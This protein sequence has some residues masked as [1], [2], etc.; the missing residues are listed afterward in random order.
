MTQDAQEIIITNRLTTGTTF[1]ARASDNTSVFVP[2]KVADAC[3]LRPGDR[4]MAV[5]V[6]NTARPERTPWVA[7]R[8]DRSVPT[9][10]E[11]E[12]LDSI[13]TMVLSA[14]ESGMMNM[15][16]II[17]ATAG[18]RPMQ[19]LETVARLVDVGQIKTKTFYALRERDFS[20]EEEQA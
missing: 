17:A 1:A 5:L 8:V 10:Q 7:V 19:V 12:T 6:P 4:V 20:Y 3:G 16:E 9:Q 18:S 14:L 11:V 15:A 2:G 13:E